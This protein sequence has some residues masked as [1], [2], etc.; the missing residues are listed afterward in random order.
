[1]CM[2]PSVGWIA[3]SVMVLG[4]FAGAC[5]NTLDEGGPGFV[6]GR[7][8]SA[9]RATAGVESVT[10][11]W[12]PVAGAS[13][14][15]V[16]VIR[17][18]SPDVDVR[19]TALPL[20]V[21]DALAAGADYSF[22][23]T[24]VANDGRRSAVSPQVGARPLVRSALS[25]Y[26]AWTATGDAIGAFFGFNLRGAGDV[27]ADGFDDV[28]VGSHGW[29]SPELQEGRAVLYLGSPDGLE[30]TSDW[31]R[32]ANQAGAFFGQ[33]AAGIGDVNGDGF[34]DIAVGAPGT[35][36][37]GPNQG[38]VYLYLGTS[39]GLRQ[40]DGPWVSLLAPQDGQ[41]FGSF[42]GP[43]GDFDGDGF[44][45][46]LVSSW[47]ADRGQA[48]EGLLLLYRGAAL[49]GSIAI[50]AFSWTGEPDIANERLGLF[51]GALLDFDGDA[52][53]DVVGGAASGEA[54][55]F[56]IN[57]ATTVPFADTVTRFMP[58]TGHR[59]GSAGDLD[60]DGLDEV[61]ASGLVA[62]GQAHVLAWNGTALE[63]VWSVAGSGTDQVGS[64]ASTAGDVNGDGFDD[65]VVGNYTFDGAAGAKVG[66]VRL[67]LGSSG[68]PSLSPAWSA[69]GEAPGDSF[70]WEAGGVGDV[71][72]DGFAD[73]MVGAY[74]H[75]L[76][77]FQEGKAYL[78]LGGQPRSGPDVEIG[79]FVVGTATRPI[80]A[81]FRDPFTGGKHRCVWSTGGSEPL[82]EIFPC[83]TNNVGGAVL[84]IS[85]TAL[86]LRLTV[87]DERDGR[88]GEAVVRLP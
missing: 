62:G 47:Q 32:A 13:R 27:N 34:D 82:V 30:A 49:P 18:S 28:I 54:Y 31:S 45:D 65:V 16:N 35:N 6:E 8:V 79:Y 71:N 75:M 68:K 58:G 14:Y 19:S 70:G 39:G 9:V 24:A 66:N 69:E 86:E 72:G 78:Y 17:S 80:G 84:A 88:A 29:S 56:E 15:E 11:R 51:S 37:N 60:G 76:D 43:A 20:L 50:N 55:Y 87:T 38:A 48:N 73:V 74:T 77:Q 83:T 61:I 2:R 1:M 33:S 12:D 85:S 81:S 57:P 21:V 5:R 40:P 63:T 7:P 46:F 26:P 4:G 64:A 10:L 59:V 36:N 3:V 67:F 52:L 23:V 22:T 53:L 42:V 41:E 44:D 25:A